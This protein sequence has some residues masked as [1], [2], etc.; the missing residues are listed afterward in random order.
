MSKL[1]VGRIGFA[2]CTPLFMALEELRA[3]GG[4]GGQADGK[5]ETRLDEDIDYVYGIPTELNQLLAEGAIDL[6]PSSS[7]AYLRDPENLC[8]L[9]DLSISSIGE[10]GSVLLMSRVPLAQLAGVEIGLTGAS[11][12]SV[13]LLR[14]LLETFTGIK[15][16][17]GPVREA[18]Q[19]VLLIGDRALQENNIVKWPYVFDLGKLWLELTGTPFVFALWTGRRERFETDPQAFEEF[20]RRLVTARQLAYR[21]YP[22]YATLAPESEWLGREKLVEY[23]G[24][25]SYDL[26]RWHLAGLKRFACEAFALGEIDTVPDFVAF[27][28]E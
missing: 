21:S 7:V 26:T 11:A 1:K 9:P 18:S 15:P 10:V 17:Y 19:A 24:T 5:A 28:V 12:T 4:Q 23:W 13:V 20:Y 27:A 16:G 22:R 6:S 14:I 3:Q 2:N 25:I 8:Y